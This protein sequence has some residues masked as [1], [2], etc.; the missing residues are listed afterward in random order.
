MNH[1]G[2][3]DGVPYVAIGNDDPRAK[4]LIVHSKCPECGNQHY[5][6]FWAMFNG[7]WIT[8]EHCGHKSRAE[9]RRRWVDGKWYE[10]DY[11]KDAWVEV[12]DEDA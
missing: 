2:D 8:C 4:E 10:F 9:N 3:I 12:E 7:E 1:S 5:Y 6:N 11:D